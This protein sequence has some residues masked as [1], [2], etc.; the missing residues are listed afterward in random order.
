MKKK[1]NPETTELKLNNEALSLLEIC[2]NT[3]HCDLQSKSRKTNYVYAR[4][5]FSCLLRKRGYGFSKV[6]SFIN[7]DHATIIHYERNLEVYLKTDDIFRNRY[8]LVE[9]EFQAVHTK[10]K[11]K[12]VANFI[13]KK[14][15]ENYYLALPHYN[16]ELINHIIFLNK[17]KKD[18]HLKIEQM[19]LQV[20]T[21]NQSKNRVKNLIDIVSQRTRIGTEIDIEKRMNTWYNGVYEK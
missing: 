17:Q 2:E 13:E 12:V 11:L 7:K 10:N 5:A 19:Q 14:D 9:E 21:L 4:M 16:K 18:L 1:Y 6:G 3:F 15:K 20:D 8:G